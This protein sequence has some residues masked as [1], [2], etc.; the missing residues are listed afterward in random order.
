M[1]PSPFAIAVVRMFALPRIWKPLLMAEIGT[2]L[3]GIELYYLFHPS[4]LPVLPVTVLAMIFQLLLVFGV[5]F[6]EVKKALVDDSSGE[7]L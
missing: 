7:T 3:A 6:L 4:R 2:G 5:T 1:K